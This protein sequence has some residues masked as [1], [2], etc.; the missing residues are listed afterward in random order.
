MGK[1]TKTD[2]KNSEAKFRNSKKDQIKIQ[3]RKN[4]KESIRI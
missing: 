3:D 4:K 1:L 2:K